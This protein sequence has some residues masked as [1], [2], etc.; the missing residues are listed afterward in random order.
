MKLGK[1]DGDIDNNSPINGNFAKRFINRLRSYEKNEISSK[2]CKID[3]GSHDNS[4]LNEY[5][6]KKICAGCAKKL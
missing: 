1:L 2:L 5:F 4:P 3:G 6:I